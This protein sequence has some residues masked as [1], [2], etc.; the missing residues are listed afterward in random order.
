MIFPPKYQ[1]QSQKSWSRV[2]LTGQISWLALL[3]SSSALLLTAI[4][5]TAQIVAPFSTPTRPFR[6][7]TNTRGDIKFVSN[8]VATCSTISVASTALTVAPKVGGSIVPYTVTITNNGA[9]PVDNLIAQIPIPA[10]MTYVLGTLKIG[11]SPLTDAADTDVAEVDIANNK[12]NFRLGTRT[13]STPSA[14]GG[15]LDIGANTK[16][17]FSLKVGALASGAIIVVPTNVSYTEGGGS[18]TPVGNILASTSIT[19]GNSSFS[20]SGNNGSNCISARTN[21]TIPGNRNNSFPLVYVDVDSDPNTFN[22]SQSQLDLLPDAEV[23]FAGLYWGG[24]S[25]NTDRNKVKFAG[26]NGIYTN[27]TADNLYAGIN[28][29]TGSDDDISYN[30]SYQ[31][32]KD[33]TTLV[34]TGGSGQYLVGNIQTDSGI[35]NRWGGWSLVVVYKSKSNTEQPRNLTVFDGYGVVAGS[36]VSIPINGFT[37]PPVGTV[38]AKIGAIVYDGD[39]GMSGDRASFKSTTGAEGFLSDSQNPSTDIF[40]STISY[41][42]TDITTKNPNYK[43]QLGYDADIFQANGIINPGD[44][45]ATI[46]LSTNSTNEIYIPG[47][48]TSSIDLYVPTVN[49]GKSYVDLNGG[50][51]EP[52]DI[53]EY[54]MVVTNNKDTAGNGDPAKNSAVTDPIPAY[55]TYVPGSLLINGVAKTDASGDD[56]ADFDG[57]KVTFRIGAGATSSLGGILSVNT[58]TL[59]SPSAPSTSTVKFRVKVNTNVPNKTPITNVAAAAYT[60]STL[61]EYTSLDIASPGVTIETHKSS[62]SGT[63]YKDGNLDSTYNNGERLLPA[64]IKVTL[65]KDLNNNNTIDSGEEVAFVDTDANGKYTFLDVF[66][67]IYKIKVDTTDPQ[68]PTGKLLITPNNLTATIAGLPIIDKNF[69]FTP[70]TSANLLLVKRITKINNLTSTSGGDNLAAYKHEPSNPYDD[71]LITIPALTPP[72]TDKWPTI[73]NSLFMIGGTNGGL[74]KTNDSIEYTIY[75]LSAGENAAKGVL[76]CDLVPNNLAFIP[77]AYNSVAAGSGG[78]PGADRGIAVKL[79]TNSIQ[80]YTNDADGDFA[81]YFPAG[82]EPSTVY[83]GISCS[84]RDPLNPTLQLPNNNGAVVVNLGTIPGIETPNSSYGYFQFQGRMK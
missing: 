43:N 49:L 41:L 10:G 65:Y 22:S 26:P 16:I 14:S 70:N 62:I 33:V 38:N 51:L 71:N 75:F 69:G 74:I 44:T 13:S 61:G 68:I 11:T 15:S 77:T 81:Q 73:N 83:P 66:D 9:V 2:I 36:T 28:Q 56:E 79:G 31:G 63:L 40:N 50:N 20:F 48:I 59:T 46:T 6:F 30:N 55:T 29:T 45:S 54:T 67:G 5:A 12:I 27:I 4:P 24:S 64:G 58:G 37:T 25:T 32:F 47:V 18:L 39:A 8:T 19:V 21:T 57:T 7:Q 35:L 76:L 82:V 1:Q 78:T 60:G 52:G 17:S 3:L 34:K 80:S 42:G 53:I 72:D 84:K 23:L